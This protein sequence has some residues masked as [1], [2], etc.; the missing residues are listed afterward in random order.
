M[1][2]APQPR[3]AQIRLRE[4]NGSR[5]NDGRELN[6]LLAGGGDGAPLIFLHGLGGSQSTW[7]VVLGDL[8]EQHRVAAIDLPGHGA[9]D[10]SAAADYSIA[11]IAGAV[12]EAI[13]KLGLSQ[14]ILV[15]HSLGGAVALQD[16]S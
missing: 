12:A 9:S 14:P 13:G 5:S 15:G 4:R 11:G 2:S 10:R 7:Q 3:Q 16:R 1:S 6:V 8:V